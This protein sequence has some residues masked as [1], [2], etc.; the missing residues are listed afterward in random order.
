V[1]LGQV[2]SEYFGSPCQFSF[3]RLLHIHH[4]LASGAGTI[5]QLVADVPSGLSLTPQQAKNLHL[6][7]EAH[8]A[9]K[10]RFTLNILMNRTLSHA[11][12]GSQVSNLNVKSLPFKIF[13]SFVLN[14]TASKRNHKCYISV[15]HKFKYMNYTPYMRIRYSSLSYKAFHVEEL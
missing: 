1:A 4:H 13:L 8:P 7:T 5:G 11:I 14:P 12:R 15:M 9:S 3:H 10:T 6:M 2:F